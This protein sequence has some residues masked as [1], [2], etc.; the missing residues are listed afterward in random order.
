[1]IENNYYKNSM[2]KVNNADVNINHLENIFTNETY[3]LAMK[4]VPLIERKVLY[5]SYIENLR[6]NDI[7]K[8]LQLSKNQVIKLRSKG[9]AHFKHNLELLYKANIV[10]PFRS[11]RGDLIL[12]NIDPQEREFN[13]LS[14]EDIIWFTKDLIN[15]SPLPHSATL[16]IS[17]ANNQK[18]SSV[19]ERDF[20]ESRSRENYFKNINNHNFEISLI[21]VLSNLELILTNL[22]KSNRNGD[23]NDE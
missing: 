12:V 15:K 13:S 16:Y 8:N 3:Y 6:L 22:L 7:C 19:Y 14:Q 21:N 10:L 4:I 9:I 20:E 17:Q 1:M 23:N 2:E 5:L 11:I 18:V